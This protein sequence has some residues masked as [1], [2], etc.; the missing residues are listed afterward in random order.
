MKS[1]RK[2]T[3]LESYHN[4]LISPMT[5]AQQL[6]TS[7]FYFVICC[8]FVFPTTN[9]AT[10]NILSCI[11]YIHVNTHEINYQK[12][13]W[14][15][16]GIHFWNLKNYWQTAIKN[17][18][19][20]YS[21]TSRTQA[22][23][24]I[25]SYQFFKMLN[26]LIQEKCC[27]IFHFSILLILGETASFLL[28]AVFVV[29]WT[30]YSYHP[31]FYWVLVILRALFIGYENITPYQANCKYFSKFI[32]IFV[33]FLYYGY[34]PNFYVSQIYHSFPLEMNSFPIIRKKF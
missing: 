12:W 18:V 10:I 1:W 30:A 9:T 11:S 17:T 27:L 20:I 4:L 26:R 5:T 7:Q 2:C 15:I 23:L 34:F 19:P 16:N 3:T 8:Y 33:V 22:L 21:P 31:F 32:F 29:V 13:N 25:H 14:W 6:S 24:L 28:F